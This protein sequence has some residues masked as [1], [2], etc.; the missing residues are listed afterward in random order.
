METKWI[1]L[2]Y[3]FLKFNWIF[4]CKHSHFTIYTS[5]NSVTLFSLATTDIG[6]A[7]LRHSTYP[8][9]LVSACQMMNWPNKFLIWS[10]TS[11]LA[12]SI[13]TLQRNAAQ[14]TDKSLYFTYLLRIYSPPPPHFFYSLHTSGNIFKNILCCLHLSVTIHAYM[15]KMNLKYLNCQYF[16]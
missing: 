10:S 15:N 13:G 8:S 1:I 5:R 3:F 4:Y 12:L 7:W 14:I 11:T 16:I 9:T 2:I 6:L